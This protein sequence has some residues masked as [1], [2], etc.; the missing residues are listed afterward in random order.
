MQKGRWTG[1]PLINQFRG[2]INTSI[3]NKISEKEL[4]QAPSCAWMHKY[5]YI[6]RQSFK[7]LMQDAIMK[8]LA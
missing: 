3:P 2:K 5:R 6:D 7:K 4:Q 8:K 1:M